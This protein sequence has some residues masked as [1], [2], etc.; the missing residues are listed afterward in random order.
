MIKFLGGSIR[1]VYNLFFKELRIPGLM[2]AVVK[3]V[4]KA[5]VDVIRNHLFSSRKDFFK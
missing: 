5:H 3:V 1:Y 2:V 4:L